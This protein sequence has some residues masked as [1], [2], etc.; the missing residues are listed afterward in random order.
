MD[1]PLAAQRVQTS[2]YGDSNIVLDENR[3]T[4]FDFVKRFD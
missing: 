1:Y 4:V 3:L 2:V